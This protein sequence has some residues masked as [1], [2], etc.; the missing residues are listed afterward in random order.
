MIYYINHVESL[1]KAAHQ[2]LW[3]HVSAKKFA[4][5]VYSKGKYFYEMYPLTKNVDVEPVKVEISELKENLS[6]KLMLMAA[7]QSAID[8]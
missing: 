8:F 1:T 7:Q 5:E 6:L 2:Q 4:Q 3:G